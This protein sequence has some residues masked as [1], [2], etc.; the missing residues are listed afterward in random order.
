M[1]VLVDNSVPA[2]DGKEPAKVSLKNGRLQVLFFRH[3]AMRDWA[4]N[5]SLQSFNLNNHATNDIR[6]MQFFQMVQQIKE[7]SLVSNMRTRIWR[8]RTEHGKT[9]RV[10]NEHF[11]VIT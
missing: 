7:C 11:W 1:V 3:F 5:S 4:E 6:L 8:D 2:H 10:F 9:A